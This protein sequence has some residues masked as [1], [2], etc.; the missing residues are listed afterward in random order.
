MRLPINDS[1]LVLALQVL[2]GDDHHP[3]SPGQVGN[4]C[5]WA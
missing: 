4:I 3:G 5:R 1:G 2:V